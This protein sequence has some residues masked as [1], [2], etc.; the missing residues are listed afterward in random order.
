VPRNVQAVEM[1]RYASGGVEARAQGDLEAL[2]LR[3]KDYRGSGVSLPQPPVG[4][5]GLR[6]PIRACLGQESRAT[7]FL[8]R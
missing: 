4:K 3:Y 2:V 1:A 5:E 7:F 6:L 8:G